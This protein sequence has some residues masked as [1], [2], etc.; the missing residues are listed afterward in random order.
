MSSKDLWTGLACL[1]AN[2]EVNNFRRFGNGR[3]AFVHLVACV[4]SKEQLMHLVEKRA[5]ELDCVLL[6]LEDVQLLES[7]MS[8][9]DYPEELIT[10][11][12]TATRQPEDTVFGTFNVWL[13]DESN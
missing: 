3:G 2:P 5:E 9:P 10:M 7:R 4:E 12:E 1:K 13:H 8:N 11:C 6:E